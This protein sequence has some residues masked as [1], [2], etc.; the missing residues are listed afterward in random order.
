MSAMALLPPWRVTSSPT[1]ST[2]LDAT[3]TRAADTRIGGLTTQSRSSKSELTALLSNTRTFRFKTPRASHCMS[4][5]VLRWARTLLMQVAFLRRFRLGNNTRNPTQL[6]KTFLDLITS[7]TSSCSS[8]SMPIVSCIIQN[9]GPLC[10]LTIIP[11]W[12]GK[13][14]TQQAVQYIYTDPHSPA[15]ARILG[16]TANSKEFREAFSCPVKE[17]TCELW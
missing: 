2:A 10:R 6:T 14:R 4:M 11:V 17:P 16:T 3:T 5:V 1:P 7:A 12:C 13:I 9:L 8:F 15:F